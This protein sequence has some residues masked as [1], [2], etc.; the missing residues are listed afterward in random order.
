MVTRDNSRELSTL[1]FSPEGPDFL[2]IDVDFLTSYVWRELHHIKPRVVCVEYN[3]HYPPSI[4]YEVPY[5]LNQAW[6]GDTRFG[7]SLKQ[8]EIIGRNL[9]Y[10]LVGC[11]LMGVN[12]FFVRQ[13][14]TNSELFLEPFTAEQHYQPP[15]FSL[16]HHRGHKSAAPERQD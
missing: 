2:S 15:R 6:Q 14:L 9:S 1:S 4:A 8:L 12:A 13:D 16:V 7:A 5:S 3:A 10:D 11:D